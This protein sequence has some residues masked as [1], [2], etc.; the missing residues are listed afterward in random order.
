MKT[1]FLSLV[2]FI[3]I[4][5]AYGQVWLDNS[6]PIEEKIS[7]E[8]YAST[9]PNNLLTLIIDQE[10]KLLI[11][12]EKNEGLSEIKF[13]EMVYD[14]ISN[15]SKDKA[16]ADSPKEAIIALGSFSENETYKLILKYIREVYLYAWDIAAQSKYES[17]YIDLD[18]KKR[19]K[20]R[21][22]NFPYNLKE[23]TQEEKKPKMII[24]VPA[25]KGDVIDN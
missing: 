15:P 16:K 21:N 11:N 19:K 3:L 12:G 20:I 6:C 17:N 22:R 25:F 10:G 4:G 13:K 1:L 7:D 23:L 18:C 5:T 8:E 9:K 14:F 2:Y 24:G